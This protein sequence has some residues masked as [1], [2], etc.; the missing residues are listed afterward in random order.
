MSGYME[1]LA[2]TAIL[3]KAAQDAEKRLAWS[4]A[5]DLWRRALDVYPSTG[6]LAVADMD[7]MDK[8]MQACLASAK[9][10]EQNQWDDWYSNLPDDLRKRLSIH[11]FKRLG[12]VFKAAFKVGRVESEG[13]YHHQMAMTELDELL[14]R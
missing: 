5:A 12:D 7:L 8:R 11:D 3:R 1:D 9:E 13:D 14:R 4:E 10:A 2:C 6:R